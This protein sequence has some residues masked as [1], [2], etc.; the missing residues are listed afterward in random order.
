MAFISWMASTYQLQLPVTKT[1]RTRSTIVARASIIA[2]AS[3]HLLRMDSKCLRKLARCRGSS[4]RV[5][6]VSFNKKDAYLNMDASSSS[7]PSS[8]LLVTAG[9]G[10]ESTSRM[11]CSSKDDSTSR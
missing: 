3:R 2:Q 9:M 1:F 6:P 10:N 5:Y 8:C 11:F 7:I 4:I